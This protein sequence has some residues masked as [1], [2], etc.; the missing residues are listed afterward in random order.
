MRVRVRIRINVASCV[1]FWRTTPPELSKRGCCFS[2]KGNATVVAGARQHPAKVSTRVDPVGMRTRGAIIP[3]RQHRRPI[4]AG[5]GTCIRL[6]PIARP[7]VKM[8]LP[9]L[10][11]IRGG[12]SHKFSEISPAPSI[13]SSLVPTFFA[14]PTLNSA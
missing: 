8:F 9:P 6:S 1:I 14:M 2:T 13:P 10:L 5:S 7:L 12:R 3:R 4:P 11:E